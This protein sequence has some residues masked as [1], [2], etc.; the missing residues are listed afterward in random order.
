MGKVLILAESD[1]GQ[2]G[3]KVVLNVIKCIKLL[4]QLL[5]RKLKVL[6]KWCSFCNYISGFICL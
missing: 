1:T 4:N 2:T 5:F 6:L 3:P